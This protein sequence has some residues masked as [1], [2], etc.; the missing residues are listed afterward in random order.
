MKVFYSLII[1]VF[2]H[3]LELLS[4]PKLSN[5]K[6]MV[7]VMG[8]KTHYMTSIEKKMLKTDFARPVERRKIK[9]VLKEIKLNQVGITKEGPKIGKA[10]GVYYVI[11]FDEKKS[12]SFKL[13]QVETT[14]ILGVWDKFNQK[15]VD[16]LMDYLEVEASLIHL[17]SLKT[18]KKKNGIELMDV[19]SNAELE[20]EGVVFGEPI[21]IDYTIIS[22]KFKEVYLTIL[23]YSSDGSVIQVFPNKYQS[24][25][26]V[27]T[28][29]ELKFPPKNA[30]G[31]YK[32]LAAPPEG[33][34]RVVV[35]ASEK[36]VRLP[37]KYSKSLG[38]YDGI[39]NETWKGTKG[40]RLSIQKFGGNYDVRQLVLDVREK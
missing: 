19:F 36:P 11:L 14:R 38:I 9:S 21:E 29:V 13:I 25:N 8:G 27:A 26:K 23:V 24:D 22:D 6:L 12:S 40:V 30:P 5:G 33:N 32:M 7:A 31:K 37:K 2:L 35:I 17:A 28:N 34:D 15:N 18:P 4:F 39:I 3:T 20:N 1:F 16:E 10:I